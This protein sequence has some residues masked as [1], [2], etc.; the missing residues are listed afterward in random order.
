MKKTYHIRD[1]E[2]I[3]GIK[4]HT[5]RMWEKR[6]NLIKP[7]RSETNIRY[8]DEKSFKKF[9]LITQL[10]HNNVKI[11]EISKLS[12]DSLKEKALILNRSSEEYEAWDLELFESIIKFDSNSFKNIIRDAIF[13]LD[14]NKVI[15]FILF[16]LLHKIDVLWKSDSITSLNRDFAFE[17][18][19]Q[20]L[21]S[22]KNALNKYSIKNGKKII[23]LSDN[24]EM[25]IFSIL[26]AETIVNKLNYNS[27]FF[28]NI[29]SLDYFL[30]NIENLPS[31][32]IITVAPMNKQKL[33]LLVEFIKNNKTYT[34]FI[35]DTNYLL[36]IEEKNAILINTLED[37][38]DEISFSLLG[39]N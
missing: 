17:E 5:I 18:V 31:K 7:K 19:R 11:S 37:L 14:L 9:L 32:K 6:Y 20:L 38:E 13:S 2:D 15:I 33:K 36:D 23:L 29:D 24:N 8:Y 26:F 30:N 35:I 16:P 39:S 12:L 4:A 1:L 10:Y 25:N 21:F 3:S 34:L 27:L 22:I 28:G